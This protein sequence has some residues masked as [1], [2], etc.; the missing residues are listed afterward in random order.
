VREAILDG[1]IPNEMTEALNR[2]IEEGRKL[3]LEPMA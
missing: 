2:M 3:G 1:E